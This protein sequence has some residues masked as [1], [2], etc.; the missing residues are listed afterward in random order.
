MLHR[1]WH[2]SQPRGADVAQ[3]GR[4]MLPHSELGWAG[5][6]C[7]WRGIG[8]CRLFCIMRDHE[9]LLPAL[10][11][12]TPAFILTSPHSHSPSTPSTSAIQSIGDLHFH[13]LSAKLPHAPSTPSS[14][15]SNPSFSESLAPLLLLM[16]PL[17]SF[18]TTEHPVLPPSASIL[19]VQWHSN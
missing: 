19:S 7:E 15:P 6:R 10:T 5:L 3:S 18:V 14:T 13:T 1:T 17:P 8:Y 12:P 9:S 2:S 11:T 4:V 16:L